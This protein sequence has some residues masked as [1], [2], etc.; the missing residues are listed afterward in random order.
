MEQRLRKGMED[1][2]LPPGTDVPALAAFYST[3]TRGMAV[4]ARDGAGAQKLQ[5][6]ADVAMQAWPAPVRRVR[7]ARSRGTRVG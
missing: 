7:S 6:I 1:G 2:D 5:A 3:V 4:Q